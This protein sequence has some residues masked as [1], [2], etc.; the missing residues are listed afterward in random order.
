MTE[1]KNR[2]IRLQ[3][4]PDNRDQWLE[5]RRRGI[6]G[7]DSAAIVGLNPYSSKLA[8]YAD[9]LGLVP[10][11]EDNEA[12]R[13]GRELEDYVAKRWEEKTGKKVQRLNA[14]LI[15]EEFPWAIANLDRKVVGE[16]SFLEIKT[17]SAWNKADF[18][19]GEIPPTYYCQVQHY[20]AV[21]GYE[22]AYLAVLVLNKAFYT[23]EIER[24]D[25]EIAAL[26]EAERIFWEEHVQKQ[27]PPEAD[28]S[29]ASLAVLDNRVWVDDTE[30]IP[31]ADRLFEQL[32][33]VN[34]MIREYEDEKDEL[35][36][37]IIQRLNGKARGQAQGWVATYLPQER[38]TVDRAKLLKFY[39]QAYGDCAETKTTRTFRVKKNKGD[40]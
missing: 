19:N 3:Y 7:S 30:L 2:I 22:K 27:V 39:P 17:T 36:N 26:M 21:S 31:D 14:M 35:K 5:M 6:G 38:T 20:L 25:R 12:M 10:E 18:A 4:D 24:D 29:E 11:R 34:S 23:F 32:E 13:E 1:T 15:N 16:R 8:V 33:S 37:L 28:G 40:K 9:K